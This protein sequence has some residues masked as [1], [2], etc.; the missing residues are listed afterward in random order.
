MS[1]E[2]DRQRKLEAEVPEGV[3]PTATRTGT[4]GDSAASYGPAPISEAEASG[5]VG[6]AAVGENE[7]ERVGAGEN[8]AGDR[9]TGAGGGTA[10]DQ[11]ATPDERAPAGGGAGSSTAADTGT[12]DR[13]ATDKSA[14]GDERTAAGGGSATAER[15]ATD[16][17]GGTA[18]E[19]HAATAE[20]T[21]A[22][23]I[24]GQPLFGAADIERLRTAWRQVQ[25]SFVDN[26]HDAVTQADHLVM[27]TVQQL[28][29][30][31]AERKQS[32]ERL[33]SREED[34]DTEDLRLALRSYRAF[35]DQLVGTGN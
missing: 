11:R 28:S 23:D 7:S 22:Q 27:A 9:P 16:Q 24:G 8:T 18:A 10:T 21:A 13:T 29:A 4:E 26:P 12:D 15:T 35:F 34:G 31:L 32:L 30:T 19:R 1:T 25:G 14:A 20:R 17:H 5:D 6:T 2:Q 3:S 33:W